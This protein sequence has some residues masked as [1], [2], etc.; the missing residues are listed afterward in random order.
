MEPLLGE[1]RRLRLK[2]KTP[3]EVDFVAKVD[4]PVLRCQNEVH[5]YTKFRGD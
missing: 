4:E 5:L 1:W 2:A 3:G